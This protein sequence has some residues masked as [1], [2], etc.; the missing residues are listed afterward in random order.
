MYV[1]KDKAVM[2]YKLDSINKVTGKNYTSILKV[3]LKKETE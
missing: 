3:I 1:Y 2:E